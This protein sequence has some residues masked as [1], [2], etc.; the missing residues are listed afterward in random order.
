MLANLGQPT[1]LSF[2][3]G[4]HRLPPDPSRDKSMKPDPGTYE[5]FD[6]AAACTALIIQRTSQEKYVFYLENTYYTRKFNIIDLN[7]YLFNTYLNMVFSILNM[8]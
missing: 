7:K 8:R 5:A 3:S 1:I 6:K 2:K 4:Q